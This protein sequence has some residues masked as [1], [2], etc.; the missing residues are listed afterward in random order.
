MSDML[1]IS[2]YV[3]LFRSCFISFNPYIRI[4]QKKYCQKSIPYV[5]LDCAQCS[6][7]RTFAISL[8]WTFYKFARQ[9]YNKFEVLAYKQERYIQKYLG[10]P[11]NSQWLF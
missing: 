10:I 5:S 1:I 4:P 7:L 11:L 2:Y 9:L 8:L 6:T 3:K